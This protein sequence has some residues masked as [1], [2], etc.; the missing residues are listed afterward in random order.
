MTDPRVISLDSWKTLALDGKA[1]SDCLLRKA[2]I[3]DELKA[4][5]EGDERGVRIAITTGAVD[6]DGDTI[7][8]DGWKLTNYRKNPV[9]LWAH[10]YRSLPIARSVKIEAA[11]G[12]LVSVAH[13][14]EP[15]L[16]P[17]AETVLQMVRHRYL[18]ASSVGFL[19]FEWKSSEDESR[20]PRRGVDF[21]KQ[22]LLEY[23]IVPVPSNPE[24]L[25][26]AR[27]VG[28]DLAPL[29]DWAERLLDEYHG[30]RG[31]YLGR[32]Q[33]E[34]VLRLV[35][36]RTLVAVPE[37]RAADAPPADPATPPAP[38]EKVVPPNVS[39]ET[40]PADAPWSRPTLADFTDKQW[41]DLSD[42]EKR[43]IAGH[44]AWANQMP[45]ATF[46]DLKLPHHD[47]KSHKAVW[48][49]VAAAMGVVMGARG[50]AEGV[51]RR[52][53]YDHLAKH[54]RQFGKE[55]PEFR[56][57][58][59]LVDELL[60]ELLVTEGDLPAPV[61][62]DPLEETLRALEAAGPEGIK[63][64]LRPIFEPA[65]AAHIGAAMTAVTGRLPD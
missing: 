28:I 18:N 65:V 36:P 42:G 24:A 6:R 21:T 8:P 61:P 29:K 1:P 17:M 20:K 32:G 37:R 47:P 56:E 64:A 15:E 3:T 5:V 26:E 14:I 30:E 40:A 35:D 23:S 2:F 59:D 48:R 19:P 31:F 50:G 10:D 25:V 43:Q 44:F 12:K 7:N 58:P 63:A 16:S 4:G 41:G 53:A 46:G 22:E 62:V 52:P 57:A 55:P 60:G 27:S 13:F 33:L 34:H 49:G 39:S 51:A 45:P 11:D 54:Y 9:V 38:E